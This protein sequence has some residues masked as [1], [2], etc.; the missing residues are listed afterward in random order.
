[1]PTVYV[2]NLAGYVTSSELL[3]HFSRAGEVVGALDFTHKARCRG[4]GA[5]ETAGGL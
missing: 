5:V 4:F 2:G 3:A 1:M